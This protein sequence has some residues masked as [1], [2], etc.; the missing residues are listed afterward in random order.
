MEKS[1]INIK[2]LSELKRNQIGKIISVSHPNLK[3][4]YRL[5]E[6]GLV[7]D[8]LVKIK[9]ISPLGDPVSLEFRNYELCIR[10]CDLT[11]LEVKLILNN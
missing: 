7:K 3:L 9:K 5:L 4:R 10:K 6:M 11:G 1:K 8:T 2:K